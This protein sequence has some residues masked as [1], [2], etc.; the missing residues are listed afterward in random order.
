MTAK[1][2]QDDPADPEAPPEAPAPS[3]VATKKKKR[4]RKKH[5]G[6]SRREELT[7]PMSVPTGNTTAA[8]APA[9]STAAMS[10]TGQNE[11]IFEMDLS[12][13]EEAAVRV[14][15]W[16]RHQRRCNQVLLQHKWLCLP[17]L[18]Y[19]FQPGF[20]S[21]S[22]TTVRD[23]DPKLPAARHNL[24]GYPLSDGDWPPDDR[25]VLT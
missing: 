8:N 7:P 18:M 21:P 22:V 2:L 19:L 3:T 9:A 6:D 24:D 10:S 20:R 13:D 17:I 16:V 11:E 4:R 1:D 15:R 14:S 25:Y 5:K 23:I 12:S